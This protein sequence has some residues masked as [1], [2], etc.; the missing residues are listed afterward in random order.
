MAVEADLVRLSNDLGRILGNARRGHLL[1]LTER[2]DYFVTGESLSYERR[3]TKL[4]LT[5][6]VIAAFV[7]YAI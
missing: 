1:G 5:L 4:K 6:F 3:V 2:F 7:A